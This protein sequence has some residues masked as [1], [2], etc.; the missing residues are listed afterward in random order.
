MS[1]GTGDIQSEASLGIQG[2]FESALAQ[3][4]VFSV[5]AFTSCCPVPSEDQRRMI[6]EALKP[7]LLKFLA[8]V[9][10]PFTATCNYLAY[11]AYNRKVPSFSLSLWVGTRGHRRSS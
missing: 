9:S 8:M 1:D 6:A 11:A 7:A 4:G 10:K 3:N 5:A 2:T